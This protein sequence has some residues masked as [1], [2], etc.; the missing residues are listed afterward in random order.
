[1]AEFQ[2]KQA[3]EDLMSALGKLGLRVNPELKPAPDSRVAMG[4]G[5]TAAGA[6][7]DVIGV[8]P[9]FTPSTPAEAVPAEPLDPPPAD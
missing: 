4:P 6:L 2:K 7:T 5:G 9:T 8:R 3:H 1:M